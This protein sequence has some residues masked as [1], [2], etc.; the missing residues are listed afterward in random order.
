[1]ADRPGWFAGFFRLSGTAPFSQFAQDPRIIVDPFSASTVAAAP[2][3]DMAELSTA[4][5]VDFPLSFPATAGE[6][7][8]R[9]SAVTTI[10]G[11][12]GPAV[13][14][15]GEDFGSGSGATSSTISVTDEL[16]QAAANYTGQAFADLE[17]DLMGEIQFSSGA[18]VLSRVRD[19]SEVGPNTLAWPANVPT[20]QTSGVDPGA[21]AGTPL[22]FRDSLTLE[23]APGYY[24]VTLD[25]G[26]VQWDLWV[27]ASLRASGDPP[28]PS[29][30][31]SPLDDN[32]DAVWTM[33]VE[34]FHMSAG[35]TEHGFFFR[36]FD[37]DWEARTRS[38]GRTITN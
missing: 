6:D 9:T 15:V 36:V 16:R 5:R 27:P 32:V 14:A 19:A 33:F 26:D 13:L 28:F 3:F 10:P 11:L 1:S 35:F 8:L 20:V 38:S 7:D 29:L 2:S 18:T 25:D 12:I 34:A 30:D 31:S 21:I 23:G 17:V 4:A 24:A 37:R 22:Q